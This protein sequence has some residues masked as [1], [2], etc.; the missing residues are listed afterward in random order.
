[1]SNALLSPDYVLEP[2]CPEY[3]APS[4]AEA[5]I[6]DQPLP[7][8]A[9]PVALSP[10]YI[11]G[12]D[13][14]EDPEKDHEEDPAD[15]PADGGDD[16]SSDDDDV[17]DDDEEEEHLALPN[18]SAV[19]AID[20]IPS[21][22]LPLPSP[23]ATSPTY[24]EAPLGY[25]AT[26]IR[27][28]AASPS[29]HH[30]SKIPS[31]P[32]LLLSTSHIDDLPE[33]DMPLRKR[34]RFTVLTFGF[35][36]RK[37]STTAAARQPGLD[38]AIVDATAR[39]LVSREVAYGIEDVWDD[40]VG[41]M[42]ER[43][44]T[45]VEGLSQR[46]TDLSTNLARD[47]HEIY[48]IPPHT[49]VLLDSKTRHAREAWSHSMNCSKAVHAEL[50]EY[51]AQVNISEIQIQIRDTRIGLLETLVTTLVAQTSSL[52]TQLTTDP[53]C[54]QTLED[55]DPEPQDRPADAGSSC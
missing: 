54:I 4:D 20:P 5:P 44:P 41:D 47:T 27:L 16:E 37:S 13:P 8:D 35:K 2:E 10:G 6:E 17:E 31:L 14:K 15:Y 12:S 52:Q 40:K 30:P 11:V 53:E 7:D 46:V 51:R 50:Q 39:R 23:P 29:T 24:V 36:V 49:A 28:R 25:R 21:P 55:R 38:V 48:E 33:A 9:S 42:K 1:M 19:L 22:S 26:M 34:A 43:A 45:T 32:L 3:L 18:S